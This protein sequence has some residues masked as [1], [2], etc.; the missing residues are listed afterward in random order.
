MANPAPVGSDMSAGTY[1]CTKMRVRAWH[2]VGPVRAAVSQ[3][4]RPVRLGRVEGWRQRQGSLPREV[5]ELDDA[6]CAD[7][8]GD[9][10][11][12]E[13]GAL[14]LVPAGRAP[15]LAREG[16]AEAQCERPRQPPALRSLTTQARF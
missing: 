1:R 14:V 8:I 2:S 9:L 7:N 11:G 16:P 6:R 3:L 5:R 10:L 12:S 13:E 15:S 4:L